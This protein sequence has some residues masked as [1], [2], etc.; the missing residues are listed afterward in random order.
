MYF[1]EQLDWYPTKHMVKHIRL[2]IYFHKIQQTFPYQESFIKLM[3][4]GMA[5]HNFKH[6]AN[7]MTNEMVEQIKKYISGQVYQAIPVKSCQI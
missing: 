5:K 3:A 6:M 4:K 1:A 7:H 2:K